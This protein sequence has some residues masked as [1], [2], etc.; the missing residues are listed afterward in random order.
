[1][2]VDKPLVVFDLETTGTWVQKDKIV[3]I[4]MIKL[5]PDG[6]QEQ[7]LK[8]VNPGMPIPATVSRIIGITDVDVKDAPAFKELAQEVL[9]FIGTSDVGGFNVKRFDLPMLEREMFEAGLRFYCEEE[10]IYDAQTIYHIHEKRDLTAAY[11]FYCDKPLDNAH[12]AMGDAQ[13]TA[14]IFAAQIKQ[15]GDAEEG[16]E[17]LRD[18]DYEKN[19]AFF[20]KE[21]KFRWWNGELYPSFGKYS[22]K[23][24][25]QICIENKSYFEWIIRSDFSDEIKELANNILHGKFPEQSV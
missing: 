14:E 7:Y 6:T 25:K 2:K 8:R 5:M 10:R 21:R 15:Y 1:M 17:S 11:K 18:F 4:G 9:D 13:A 24:V 12:S 23:N 3:E 19:D 20:D 16:I 22:N